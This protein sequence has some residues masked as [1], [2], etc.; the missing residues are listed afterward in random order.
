MKSLVHK[1]PMVHF[2]LLFVVLAQI[3]WIFLHSIPSGNIAPMFYPLL[4]ASFAI[5]TYDYGQHFCALW[6]GHAPSPS[7]I[8]L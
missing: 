8:R 4:C 2:T 6:V 5:K 7:N 3:Q 1:R